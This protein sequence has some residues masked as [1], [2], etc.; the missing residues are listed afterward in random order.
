[1]RHLPPIIQV[2]SWHKH[3]KRTVLPLTC[4][5]AGRADPE[6]VRKQMLEMFGGKLSSGS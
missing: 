1:M 5:E 2:G 3:R 4:E 6:E